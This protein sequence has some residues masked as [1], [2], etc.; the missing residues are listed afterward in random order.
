[1]GPVTTPLKFMFAGK[2]VAFVTASHS[3]SAP[4]RRAKWRAKYGANAS[5]HVPG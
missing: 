2:S 1:M 3:S 5:L 4:S